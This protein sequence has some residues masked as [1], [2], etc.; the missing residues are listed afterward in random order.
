MG[1]VFTYVVFMTTLMIVLE[2]IG[3]GL[4]GS[5]MA[6]RL[7]FTPGDE[8]TVSTGLDLKTTGLWTIVF[9]TILALSLG[10]IVIG[11]FARSQ[12]ENF[13][14]LPFI[15]GTAIIFIDVAAGILKQVQQYPPFLAGT[16]LVVYLGLGIGF[17][18]TM[19][20][21]FRGNV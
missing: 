15:T 3:L 6:Q 9:G 8:G 20:E 16:I 5:E 18:V 7:G 10:G 12:T 17:I 1:R 2:L 4:A 14:V 21:W 11:F 19:V 13:I